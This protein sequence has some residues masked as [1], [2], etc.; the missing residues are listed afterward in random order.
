[1]T[2]AQS[3]YF[4]GFSLSSEEILFKNF[5]IK[6]NYTVAGFSYG[7]QKAFEYVL[8]SKNRIDKLQLFSPAFFQCKDKKYKRM[9]LMFFK[10][11]PTEYCKNFL[12]N[13]VLPNNISLDKYFNMGSFEQLEELLYYEWS[14]EKMKILVKKNI[15]IEVY[16]A[17]N[18]K[19]IDSSEAKNFFLKYATVYYIKD[20]GHI[21]N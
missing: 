12:I 19:I 11:N 9:Q 21:L 13:C 17:A 8:N 20:V 18:D 7:A 15:E 4:S 3:N 5:I 10:K 16:L 6:N 2:L 14:E 1:M